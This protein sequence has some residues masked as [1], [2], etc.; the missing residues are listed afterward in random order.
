MLSTLRP[1]RKPPAVLYCP[2]HRPHA[3]APLRRRRQGQAAELCAIA[4]K[5]EHRLHLRY[6][7]LLARGKP[8]GKVVTAIGRE[9]LGFMWAVAV[10]AEDG[11]T[12]PA[13]A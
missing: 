11:S 1:Y 6:R 8:K 13:A 4:E 9:L 10:R 7:R 12:M 3:G 2:Q 5:A